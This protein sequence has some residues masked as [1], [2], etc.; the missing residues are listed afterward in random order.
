MIL[1][2]RVVITLLIGWLSMANDDIVD[3]G[4]YESNV[5]HPIVILF[6]K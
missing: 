5:F 6:C 3:L 2:I 1:L 4:V